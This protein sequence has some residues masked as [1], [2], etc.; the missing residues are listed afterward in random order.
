M[1]NVLNEIYNMYKEKLEEATSMWKSE[2]SNS[3]SEDE[4]RDKSDKEDLI[5]FEEL[6]QKINIALEKKINV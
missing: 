6:L 5:Y 3:I 1:Y 2:Y 4:D